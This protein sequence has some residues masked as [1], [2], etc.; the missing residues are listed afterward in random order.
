MQKGQKE[1][2][3]TD[4]LLARGG[5]GTYVSTSQLHDGSSQTGD[6]GNLRTEREGWRRG[7]VV[8]TVSG[9]Q[10]RTHM[11]TWS[12]VKVAELALVGVVC[13]HLDV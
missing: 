13:V 10:R 8:W 3:H 7:V 11:L 4:P 12:A 6:S 2:H 5:G 9:W 1:P